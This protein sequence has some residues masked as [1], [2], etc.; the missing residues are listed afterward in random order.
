MKMIS[1]EFGHTSNPD[2]SGFASAQRLING[3]AEAA[4]QTAKAPLPVYAVPGT[5]RFDAASNPLSGPCR[6]MLNV[7]GKGLYVIGGTQVALF[8]ADGTATLCTGTVPGN[9]VASMA[10]NQNGTPQIGIVSNGTYSVLDTGANAIT[11]PGLANLPSPNSVTFLDGYLVFSIPNG[12]MYHT[13]LN[14]ALTVNALAYGTIASRAGQ[15]QRVVTFRGALICLKDTSFEIWED[16]GTTPFAFARIRA[17]ID[18]GC[19]A[20]ASVA[21]VAETLIWVDQNSIV[22]QLTASEPERI[23]IHALERAID[24]LTATERA[25]LYGVYTQYAGHACYALTSP[26]WTWEFDLAT[27]LWRERASSGLPNWFARGFAQYA[28]F[29]LVGSQSDAHLH[30]INAAAMTESGNPFIFTAQSAPVHAFPKGLAF[31]R[32]DVDVIPGVG[33]TG[34]DAD[35]ASPQIMLDWSDDGG[36]TWKGGRT[37]SLGNAGERMKKVSFHQLGTC[38]RNGRTFRLSASSSVMRGIFQAIASVTPI[39]A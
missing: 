16:A 14:D 1:V 25:S 18:I 17:N 11:Q 9:D 7:Y 3:Y 22:R 32:F 29:S 39:S 34:T 19:V 5:V 31:H 2:Q 8:A 28:G 24:A 12:R 15:F 30:A 36:R 27:K 6:G 21:D 20:P 10:V 26:Y 35:A 37:A 13:D 23:S 4:G 33:V 38:G